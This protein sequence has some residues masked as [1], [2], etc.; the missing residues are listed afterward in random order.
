MK[1]C[2]PTPIGSSANLRLFWTNTRV[3]NGAPKVVLGAGVTI[4]VFGIAPG[5]AM[6]HGIEGGPDPAV[7]LQ[8]FVFGA[9]FVLVVFFVALALLWTEPRLKDGP[10]YEGPGRRVRTRP[11]LAAAGVVSLVLVIG[12]IV[13]AIFGLDRDPT[14]PTIAPVMVWVVFW[15]VV[16]FA[17][18]LIGSWYTDLNPWRTLASRG[19]MDKPHILQRFGVWPAAIIF[20]AF[21]WFGLVN[22]NSGDPATLGVAALAYTVF[23]SLVMGSGG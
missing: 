17:S 7:P 19:D 10:R 4:A 13:P 20:I 6:A 1:W 23:L 21:T 9:V 14:R 18:P 8:Y 16:P 22:P 5:R 11:I 12:Q 3:H 2:G 15:L